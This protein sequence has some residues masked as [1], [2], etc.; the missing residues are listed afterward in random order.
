MQSDEVWTW[1]ENITHDLWC[2]LHFAASTGDMGDNQV[3]LLFLQIQ[4]GHELVYYTYT[5]CIHTS[6]HTVCAYNWR[7]GICSLDPSL[8]MNL[9][10]KCLAGMPPFLNP[11]NFLFRSSTWYNFN[12]AMY[13]HFLSLIEL[14]R[15]LAAMHYVA[16]FP[17]STLMAAFQCSRHFKQGFFSPDPSSTTWRVWGPD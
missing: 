2:D 6:K 7:E 8:E 14:E 10:Q 1:H 9:A 13:I 17:S 16:F 3:R 11:A 4:V 12:V 5:C 15:W